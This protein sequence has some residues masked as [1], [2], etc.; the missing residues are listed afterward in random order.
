MSTRAAYEQVA[1]GLEVALAGL[2]RLMEEPDPNEWVDQETSP[3][4]R[5]KHNELSRKGALDGAKKLNG[6]W[7]VRRRVVDAYIDANGGGPKAAAATE[8]EDDAAILNF[9]AP[10][11]RGGRRS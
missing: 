9:R 1:H 5:R 3:L 7:L 6:R 11:A 2:K 10:P 8:T 4:G